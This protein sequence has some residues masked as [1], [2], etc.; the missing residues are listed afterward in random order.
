MVVVAVVG[1][2]GVV[3]VVVVVTASVRVAILLMY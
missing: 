3:S 2:C 1:Y